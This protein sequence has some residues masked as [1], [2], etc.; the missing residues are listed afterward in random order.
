MQPAIYQVTESTERLI[1]RVADQTIVVEAQDHWAAK[2]IRELFSGWYLT[3]ESRTHEVLPSPAIVIGSSAKPPEIPRSWPQFEI[4]GGGICFTEGETSYIDI[5]GSIVAIG[6]P[7]N[8]AV[9]VWT[10]GRLEIQSPVLTRVVTYALAAALRRR[11]MFELHSGAVIDPVSGQG[12]L[13]IGPSGS[14]KSTLTVQL[15]TAGWPFLTDDVLLLS[16]EGV[17]VKAWPL[18]RCFAITSE[19]LAASNFLRAS[20]SLNYLQAERAEQNKKQ[21]LP[22]NV[23]VSEFKEHC[24][25]KTLYFS[26]ISGGKRSQVSR[27]SRA[28]TMARLI[29]M[30][31]WSC[32]DRSTAAEH[33]AVL[34][35]LAKQSTGFSLLAGKDLL[36]PA[37]AVDLISGYARA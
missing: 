27:L 37:R 4:A 32:Y 9:E 11:R 19:T 1:Y 13:I 7:G 23:F 25:P 3:P 16:A 34:S 36:D 8:N 20:A 5:D 26:Q 29:R 30:S 24:L 6:Q 2:V 22:H 15:A 28:E 10:N 14:G 33:L 18:R 12:V 21:F 35:A 31:P 17:E